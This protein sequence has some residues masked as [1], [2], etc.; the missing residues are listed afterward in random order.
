ML[1]QLFLG[2]HGA[3]QGQEETAAQLALFASQLA[4][5]PIW[6]IQVGCG[7]IL[8]R[9]VAWPPSVGQVRAACVEAC[10]KQRAELADID[11]IL[12]ADVW[13]EPTDNERAKVNEGFQK[14]V[15]ELK[16]N[17][18]YDTSRPKEHRPPTQ[19]EALAWLE[20][21]D[22]SKPLPK[23][24]DTARKAIGAPSSQ[25]AAA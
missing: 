1:A 13:H 25:G 14:L 10:E 11:A 20:A 3:R 12:N 24:S 9:N 6:A 19:Q 21:Q 15:Q 18:P 22:P 4:D 16:L 23:L 17:A 5:L 2:F 8:R 7:D